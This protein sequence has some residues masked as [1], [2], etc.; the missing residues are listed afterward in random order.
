MESKNQI[1]IHRF[2]RLLFSFYIAVLVYFLLLSE[3]CKR[4]SFRAQEYRYN[5]VLFREIKRFW[6]YRSVVGYTAAFW[7]LA[8]NILGFVPFGFLLPV[9][10]DRVRSFWLIT[11]LGMLFSFVIETIQLLC[12]VGCFDVDDLMLNT[13]G[14]ATGG[15]MFLICDKMRSRSL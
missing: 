13:I 9:L 4:G 3:G 5:L 15:L 2:G 11:S 12:K 1:W 7:N 10:H 6:K 8:G 14:A